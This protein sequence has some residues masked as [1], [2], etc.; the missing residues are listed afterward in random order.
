VRPS[1]RSLRCNLLSIRWYPLLSFIPALGLLHPAPH[2]SLDPLGEI[3]SDLSDTPFDRIVF[4]GGADAF[5]TASLLLPLPRVHTVQFARRLALQRLT[6][7]RLIMGFLARGTWHV[8]GTGP[9][10]RFHVWVK[11]LSRGLRRG[12]GLEGM[13]LRCRAGWVRLGTELGHSLVAYL[14]AGSVLPK[15]SV[16][17]TLSLCLVGITK[18][19][20][21]TP[22]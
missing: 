4:G 14:L 21:R 8:Q 10:R 1:S 2:A 20:Q 15:K 12:V 18:H 19:Y 3:G 6:P 22:L 9:S 5:E 13:L 17:L 11:S 16:N 7:G